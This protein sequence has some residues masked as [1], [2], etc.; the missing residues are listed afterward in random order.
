MLE[1]RP[2]EKSARITK[3]F[4]VLTEAKTN[5]VSGKNN[6]K[7]NSYLIENAYGILLPKFQDNANA[8]I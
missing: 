3:S 2:S 4:T 8:N 7:T 1:I 5:T 6:N